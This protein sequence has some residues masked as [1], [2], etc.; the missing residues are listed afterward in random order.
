MAGSLM[1]VAI[2]IVIFMIPSKTKDPK[3]V[4]A[5]YD[6]NQEGVVYLVPVL[7]CSHFATCTSTCTVYPQIDHGHHRVKKCFK[8]REKRGKKEMH[9][10]K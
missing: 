1:I 7:I 6:K 2:V 9:Y 10:C 8:L 5:T 4:A 3:R